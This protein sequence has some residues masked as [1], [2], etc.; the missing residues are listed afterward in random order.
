MYSW[1]GSIARLAV[2]REAVVRAELQEPGSIV[3]LQDDKE[4]EVAGV[5]R[6]KPQLR[7]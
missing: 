1:V 5:R 7:K 2:E 4:R 3:E 6:E